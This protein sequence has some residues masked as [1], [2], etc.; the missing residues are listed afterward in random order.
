MSA[1]VPLI[2]YV[3]SFGLL[4]GFSVFLGFLTMPLLVN[5]TPYI[6]IFVKYINSLAFMFPVD[7]ILQTIQVWLNFLTALLLFRLGK[8]ILSFTNAR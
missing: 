5:A 8:W 2:K 7:S 6:Y 1:F 4:I 3:L